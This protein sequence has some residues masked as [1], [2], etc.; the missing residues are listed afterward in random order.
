M[1]YVLT[2]EGDESE[3][4]GFRSSDEDE[5]DTFYS[6][7]EIP[8][9]AKPRRDTGMEKQKSWSS[10]RKVTRKRRDKR[11]TRTDTVIST[12]SRQKKSIQT[13]RWTVGSTMDAVMEPSIPFPDPSVPPMK[14]LTPYQYFGTFFDREIMRNIAEQT[15]LYSLQKSKKSVEVDICEI[16]QFIGMLL[17]MG[18]YKMPSVR[19]YWSSATRYPA[20]SEVMTRN[21]F[22]EIKRSLHFNDNEQMKKREENGYDRLFKVRPLI[23]ALRTN[24]LK[25]EPEENQSI[26]EIM[27]PSKAVSPLRQFNK[28]KPHRF[29]I[30]VEGR[31][32]SDGFLHDFNI[33]CGK[34]NVPPTGDWG[35]SGDAV[36]RL[37][38]TLPQGLPYRIFGDNW[39]SSYH[40]VKELKSRG[41][42]YTGTVRVN[43][44]PGI[45][46]K[47]DKDLKSQGRGAYDARISSDGIAV[48]KWIDN[49]PIH[50]ISS[51]CGV[52][53]IDKVKRWSGSEKRY[54]EVQ[55]PNIVGQYNQH[56]GGIDLN[57]FLVALYRTSLG[58]K[59]YYIRI[60]FHFIDVAVV[61]S[62]LLYR[63]H[64]KQRGESRYMTLLE[65]RTKIAESLL[66]Y[67]KKV[68][69][70]RGRPPTS[71]T[72]KTKVARRMA[73]TNPSFDV[74]YD[75]VAH[76][77][78]ED[79]RSRCFLCNNRG[80][81]SVFKCSKCNVTLCIQ[82]G[83]NCFTEF[84]TPQS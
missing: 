39:F 81:F 45:D 62:W 47:S 11:S 79:R 84:H 72:P 35:V 64:Q 1:D 21:R 78:V 41:F 51:Y 2:F 37:I 75:D 18:I 16:E 20:V 76:W 53:P 69:K 60:F 48:V 7:H 31:A 59:R 63:R 24:F 4:E 57:D 43:R 28:N 67:G 38:D 8:N 40:L 58:T 14:P 77:P 34:S 74:R 17:L 36:L 55:R 10:S 33:Y 3:V 66:L 27:I 52:D 15:N 25:V 80:R 56:M 68:V 49:K 73:P 61:N 26:D 13:P 9:N 71:K 29:G 50:M 46:L 22:E 54:I 12:R 23:D 6:S 82:K 30:K 5:V 44:I 65:F 19:S 70:R 32:G 42:H 83:R